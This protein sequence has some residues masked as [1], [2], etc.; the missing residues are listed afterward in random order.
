MVG[1]LYDRIGQGYDT[2]RRADPTIVS[3]LRGAIG[4]RQPVLD[5]GCGTGN[6]AVA[7]SD[8]GL[9]IV[10]VDA[11]DEML[12]GARRKRPAMQWLQ[13]DAS[14]L[15]FPDASF[16]TV[17]AVN[18]VH[19]FADKRPYAEVRRILSSGGRMAIFGSTAEQIRS[20]WLN[21]YF[22]EAISRSAD[23][24]VSF[25]KLEQLAAAA[26]LEVCEVQPWWQP[27]DPVDCFLYCG[28]HRPELYLDP[29]IRA[30]IST[31]SRLAEAEELER[32]L[33]R[34]ERDISSGAIAQAVESS[35]SPNGDYCLIVL[36]AH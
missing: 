2:H 8:S 36:A 31:F 25:S 27:A 26:R 6:Y 17:V 4:A 7:L 20:Y 24:A 15:P 5:L 22:P 3:L 29:S 1:A 23:E 9:Q 14:R 16:G 18:V 28:K 30:G 12:D 19:H 11:S 35:P 13:S 33:V 32:G 21:A 34:L 10:G